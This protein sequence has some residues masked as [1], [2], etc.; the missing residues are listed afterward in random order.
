MEDVLVPRSEEFEFQGQRSKVIGQS[1][2]RQKT[3]CALPSPQAA[4]E[5]FTLLHDALQRARCKQRHAVADGT[6]PLLPGGDFGGLRSVYV[7]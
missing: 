6:I 3:R 1:Y 4:N 2:K 7:W 5:W